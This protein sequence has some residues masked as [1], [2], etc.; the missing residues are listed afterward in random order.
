[1]IY[2]HHHLKIHVT[3]NMKKGMH[4]GLWVLLML[5]IMDIPLSQVTIQADYSVGTLI[6][7]S[8]NARYKT[9]PPPIL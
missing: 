6:E 2:Y 7:A 4:F 1:M 9:L 3:E 5:N 8:C